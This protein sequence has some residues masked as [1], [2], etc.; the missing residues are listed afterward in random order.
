MR[1]DGVFDEAFML[2]YLDSRAAGGGDGAAMA[3]KLQAKLS[4]PLLRQPAPFE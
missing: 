4:N 1:Q 3:R 2:Q